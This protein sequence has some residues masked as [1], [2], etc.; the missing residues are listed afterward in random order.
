M[1]KILVFSNGEK[2]GDGIIKL[3]FIYDLKKS[4]NDSQIYWLTNG[5]TVY[6]TVLKC[7]VKNKLDFVYENS[8]INYLPFMKLSK[9]YQLE[10]I[11]FDLV[12]DTQKT[13]LKTLTLKKLK[14]K[15]FLSNSTNN[16]LSNIKSNQNFQYKKNVYYVENLYNL[17][18]LFLNKKIKQRSKIVIP[19]EKL[20]KVS[21]IFNKKKKYFGIA[22][23]AGERKKI[24]SYKNYIKIV[25][26]FKKEGFEPCFFFGPE[27][28]SIRKKFL[29]Y[30]GSLFEP[31]KKLSKVMNIYCI[32]A[33]TKFLKFS[34]AND[35]GV[36]HVLSTGHS[37]LFKIFDDKKPSKFNLIN[38]KI[39]FIAPNFGERINDIGV[40]KVYK[41]IK[42]FI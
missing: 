5:N 32:M 6:K 34:V 23:G 10:K 39:K 4:F 29:D 40:K 42:K 35:S 36:S 33:C 13:F 16:L 8:N 21:E 22:P 19:K 1:K 17:L 38:Q 28:E 11:E 7:F 14:S 37:Y 26:L 18:E 15:F 20:A 2:L 25:D 24:W 31:E 3:P 12:I 30:F 27:D 41:E 9:K